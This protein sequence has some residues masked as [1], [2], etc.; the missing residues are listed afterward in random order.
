MDVANSSFGA[1]EEIGSESGS[2][3]EEVETVA[4]RRRRELEESS[5]EHEEETPANTNVLTPSH[6]CSIVSDEMFCRIHDD[7]TR[8][9]LNCWE[10][11]RHRNSRKC[12]RPSLVDVVFQSQPSGKT[13][14]LQTTMRMTTSR[15]RWKR[16]PN[17]GSLQSFVQGGVLIGGNY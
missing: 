9:S 12:P 10:R 16:K 17:R 11:P 14:A 5:D 13:R 6:S 8:L 1:E 15:T 4:Q 3:E 7:Q 2:G